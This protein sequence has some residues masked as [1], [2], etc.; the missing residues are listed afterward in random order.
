[1]MKIIALSVIA[2]VV[3]L[4]GHLLL[5]ATID[6]VAGTGKPDDNGSIGQ[7]TAVN[8]GQPF[9]IEVGPDDALYITEVQ[10]HRVMRVDRKSGQ[11][12]TVAGCGK[13]GHSGDGGKATEAKLNEPYEVRFDRK[14][15]MYFVE[16]MNHVVRRVD[17]ATGVIQTIAGTGE[18]GFE[19]DGGLATHAQFNRPHS[20]AL[21]HRGGLYVA[22]IGNHRIRRIDLETGVI[23]TIAGDGGKRPPVDGQLALGNSVVGPRALFIDGDTMWVALREGHSVWTLSLTSGTWKHIAGTGKQGFGG[24]NGPAINAMFNGPKG[25]AVGPDHNVYVVDTENQVIRMIDTTTHLISTVAGIGPKQRGGDGDRGPSTEAQM[26]RPHG[27]GIGPDG[28]IYI[29]DTNNH[30]VRCVSP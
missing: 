11:L 14:G 13:K 2:W 25:I 6:T 24:D 22:D 8:V 12:T 1:M 21:D 29:G 30:R 3:G 28:L 4:N 17:A 18:P 16:M 7:A 19:G 15:N 9:G 27:I 5:A 20:I 26:D 10:N 23:D